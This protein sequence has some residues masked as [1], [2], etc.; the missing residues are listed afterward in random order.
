MKIAIQTDPF[1]S[2]TVRGDTTFALALAAQARGHDLW[3]YQP[4]HLRLDGNHVSARGRRLFDLKDEQGDHVRLGEE[5]ILDLAGMDV[6]LIRQDPP[7]DMVYMTAC[8]ILEKLPENVLVLNDPAEIRSAPEKL[9]VMDYPELMPPTLVTSDEEAIRAFRDKHEDIILKPLYGN[10]GAGV[11]R[12]RSDDENFSSL[13]EMFLGQPR[14]LPIIAQ[15]YLKEVRG[16]DKRVILLDGEP[17]GAINRVPA[18]GEARSNMHVGG[19]AE[20]S[21]LTERDL[22]IC[23]TIAP[24]LKERRLVLTGIDVIGGMLTEINVT[25]PTGIRELKR[26]G[27]NDV[28]EMFWDW[29]EKET[30]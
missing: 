11:F 4:E 1:R 5:E 22:E 20:P 14:S 29:C 7:F 25:S 27:G 18:D 24:A 12:V 6:V 21:E 19:R 3:E 30:S 28:A 9:F 13:L 2:L 10:G 8:Y 16:G 17:V 26:F 23:A 15:A